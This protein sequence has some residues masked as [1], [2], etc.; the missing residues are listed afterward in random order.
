MFV[1][2]VNTVAAAYDTLTMFALR[3]RKIDDDFESVK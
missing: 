1:R 2:G 3:T